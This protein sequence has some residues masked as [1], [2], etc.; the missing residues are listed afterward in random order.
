MARG[1]PAPAATDRRQGSVERPSAQPLQQTI[2]RRMAESRATVPDIELRAE[3]DMRASSSTCASACA[4]SPIRPR[5]STTSSSGPRRWRCARSRASTAPTATA[6]VE[7][8]ARVNVG[9]A[10][11]AE[12]RCWCRRSSTPTRSRS[13]EIGR[14]A[15]ALGRPRTRRLDHPGRAVGRDVHGLQPGHVRDRQLL[16]GDQPAA[17]G[18]PRRGRDAATRRRRP[19]SGEIVAR[20]TFELTLAC[21]HRSSTEPTARAS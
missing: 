8:Y 19:G 4:R 17:G 7:T 11:A 12:E 13:A 16:G 14:V 9:I 1:R 2:A 21:D 15:R 18:D 10:V 20:P 3:V 5:R 6:R